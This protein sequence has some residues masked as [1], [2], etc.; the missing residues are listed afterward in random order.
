MQGGEAMLLGEFKQEL[1]RLNNRINMEIFGQGLIWQ[2]MEIFG[3]KV[4][5]I[6]HN[7]RVK[8]LTSI[9]RQDSLHSKLTD[10]ALIMDFKERFI[11]L[12]EDTM[13]VK[14]LAHL[15]DYDPRTELSF[16]VTIF[17]KN[18]DELIKGIQLKK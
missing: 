7:K 13:G 5:I 17:E 11:K 9:D 3:D 14:V 15:K 10:I 1:M 18:I 8:A 2:R 16:S 12:V 6:A 4:L